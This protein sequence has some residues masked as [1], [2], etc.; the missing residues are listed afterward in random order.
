MKPD[1]FI[2]EIQLS[3]RPSQG[4]IMPKWLLLLQKLCC[5]MMVVAFFSVVF[6]V[7]V[8]AEFTHAIAMRGEV[9]YP[10]DFTHFD[11]VNP[12]APQ[13]G[14]MRFGAS[15]S[16]D[17]LNPFAI[18]GRVPSALKWTN[19]IF[20]PLMVRGYDESFSLYAHIAQAVE[21]A[22]DRRYIRFLIHPSAIF[23]DGH[24]LTVDDVAFSFEKL[25]AEGRPGHRSHYSKVTH[26][27]IKDNVISFY[28]NEGENAE[29]PLLMANMPILPK[30]IYENVD[31][32]E[33]SLSIPI[34]SGPYIISDMNIGDDITFTRNS[35]YWANGLNS[36]KGFYNF[37]EI[38]Y[39]YFRDATAITEAMKVGDIAFRLESDPQNWKHALNFPAGQAGKVKKSSFTLKL[40]KPYEAMVMNSRRSP[41]DNKHARKAFF[42]LFDAP[43]V[44]QNLYDNI[45]SRSITLFHGSALSPLTIPLSEGEKDLL[46]EKGIA[47]LEEEAQS[48]AFTSYQAKLSRRKR[49]RMALALLQKAGYHLD[50]G[51][52]IDTQG[53]PLEVE[54]IINSTAM[55]AVLLNYQDMLNAVGIAL[56]I[57]QLDSAQYTKRKRAFNYD[58]IINSWY[59]SLS[60]GNEQSLYWT[61]EAAKTPDSRNYMGVQEPVIDDIV[62]VIATT[63]DEQKLT[64]ATR[65]L[66]RLFASGY[67]TIPLYHAPEQWVLH[68]DYL[69]MPKTASWYGSLAETWW[70]E[71]Q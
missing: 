16:F 64:D 53:K 37:E 62:N 9:K 6:S 65:S 13:T 10:K 7:N 50:K 36:V 43:K 32:T 58:M 18:K 39:D 69:H 31:L 30:H 23:S 70:Y 1:L 2:Y 12:N 11:Y 38:R 55:E 21:L 4:D 27:D 60:P 71:Q 67:Y 5:F 41:F 35:N 42:L 22:E 61:S 14:K 68:W 3:K 48:G 51:K 59:F 66:A 47:L 20:E 52:M 15:G 28:F 25:K 24:P 33:A 46:G 49:M 56:S 29:A 34:G 40:P 63:L 44:N 8:K 57:R 17:T 54:F 26:Y 45:F 19:F